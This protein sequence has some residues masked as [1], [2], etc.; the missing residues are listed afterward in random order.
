M[1]RLIYLIVTLSIAALISCSKDNNPLDFQEEEKIRPAGY[2]TIDGLEI[3]FNDTCSYN[4]IVNF[5]SGF[6]SIEMRYLSFG[7]EFDLYADSA[8]GDYWL[9]Y[10]KD[11]STL[12]FV[13]VNR[14]SDSLRIHIT[15]TGEKTLDEELKYFSSI[16][17]LQILNVDELQRTAYIGVPVDT[18]DIWKEKFEEY[19]FIEQVLIIGICVES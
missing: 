17:H 18:E 12:Q 16:N 14:I 9:K 19:F 5:L 3:T 11:D 2:C 7:R 10:F 8:G 13:N 15:T 4:F 6:D 1:N